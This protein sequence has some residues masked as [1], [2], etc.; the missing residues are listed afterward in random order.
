MNGAHKHW[1]NTRVSPRNWGV[2]L[3]CGG[4][5][6][7]LA[8]LVI[9]PLSRELRLVRAEACRVRSAIAEQELLLPAYAQALAS[10]VEPLPEAMRFSQRKQLDPGEVQGLPALFGGMAKESGLD[11]MSASPLMIGEAWGRGHLTVAV[12]AR[13]DFAKLRGFLLRALALPSCE[14]LRR[15]EIRH[16]PTGEEIDIE[17]RL[18][19]R[20]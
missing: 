9:Y 3:T 14:S 5:V 18:V 13:G 17:I 20:A 16:T 12:A 7:L 11:L 15:L 10:N 2:I 1:M 4:A 6:L 19:V 8:A